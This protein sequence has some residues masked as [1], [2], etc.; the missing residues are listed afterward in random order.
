ILQNKIIHTSISVFP[1]CLVEHQNQI[2]ISVFVDLFCGGATVGLNVDAREII[3][4]DNNHN[5]INLLKHLSLSDFD[6]LLSRLEKL[7]SKY[8]LSYSAK[9]G[10]RQ[11]RLGVPREDNNGL[12]KYNFLGYYKLRSDYNSLKDKASAY[13]LD[14]L[15]LC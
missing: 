15:Y 6:V 2:M 8:G 10:Y 7:I 1:I 5:V 14:L 3:F 12:K 9:F 4:L 13:A 11:Y